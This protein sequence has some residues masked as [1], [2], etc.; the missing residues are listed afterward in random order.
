M[1]YEHK[2]KGARFAAEAMDFPVSQTIKTLVVHV[3]HK[4]YYLVLMPGDKDLDLK[5]LAKS[6]SAKRAAMADAATAERLTGY[7]VGGISP[8]RT[9]KDLPV[10]I[11]ESLMHFNKVAVNGGKRGIMLIMHP[12]DI[13]TASRADV[14]KLSGE[15]ATPADGH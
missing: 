6:L 11:D 2:H 3:D 9:K 4:G 1:E 12:R 7:L 13:L 14:L 10:I 8:F 5:H 15:I